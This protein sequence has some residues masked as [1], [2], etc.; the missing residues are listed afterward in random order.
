MTATE[1][2][3]AGRAA[4][5][6]SRTPAVQVSDRAAEVAAFLLEEETGLLEQNEAVLKVLGRQWPGLTRE[7][8]VRA[9]D[10]ALELSEV[11]IRELEAEI[12]AEA[13]SEDMAREL[14]QGVRMTDC[15]HCEI[16]DLVQQRVKDG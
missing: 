3:G 15:L 5:R 6:A 14:R 10:I 9:C 8:A 12:A 16:N 2:Q 7:E 11:R 1:D 4:N 13:A